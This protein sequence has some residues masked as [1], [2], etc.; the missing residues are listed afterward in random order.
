MQKVPQIYARN[1]IMTHLIFSKLHL[2]E[3]LG[4]IFLCTILYKTSSST[5][6]K[7]FGYTTTVLLTHSSAKKCNDCPSLFPVMKYFP[8]NIKFNNHLYT[9]LNFYEI[10]CFYEVFRPIPCGP[11]LYYFW[12]LSLRKNMSPQF[13]PLKI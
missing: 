13:I 3:H 9:N 8:F 1:F 5:V 2:S 10:L 12:K 6:E 11:Q 7:Q 4:L